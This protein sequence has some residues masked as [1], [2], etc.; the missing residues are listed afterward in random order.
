MKRK[1]VEVLVAGVHIDTVEECGVKQSR[2]TVS[3]KFSEPDAT[4]PILL[5]Q[6]YGSGRVIRIP[7]QPQTVGDHIRRRRLGMKL[8]QREAAE[9][10]GVDKASVFNWESNKGTPEIRFM[11]AII[12]FLGYNPL[13]EAKTLA[14][15]LVRH[16]TTLGLSRNEAALQLGV[17]AGTLARWEHGEREPAGELLERVEQF[18]GEENPPLARRAG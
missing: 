6:S 15:Q 3:Y 14:E 18:V 5:N 10:L 17:D 11:P 4:L 7:M 16:R 2:I 9:Q 1:L 12:R 8:L 13:P